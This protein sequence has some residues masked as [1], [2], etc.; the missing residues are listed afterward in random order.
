MDHNRE[1]E[2]LGTLGEALRGEAFAGDDSEV[3]LGPGFA[4]LEGGGMRP[5]Y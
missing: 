4:G 3:N 5:C 1:K 2:S